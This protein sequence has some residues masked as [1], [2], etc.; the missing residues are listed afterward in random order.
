MYGIV[1]QSQG[2]ILVETEE[3]RCTKFV[4]QLPALSKKLT[5]IES[6]AGPAPATIGSETVLICDDNGAVA[7]TAERMLTSKGYH[8]IVAAGPEETM[9]ELDALDGELD[10]LITDVVMPSMDGPTLAGCVLD[11]VSSSASLRG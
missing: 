4:V 8:V 6:S 3:G 9:L 7:R 1:R 2:C 5:T 10:L 11:G